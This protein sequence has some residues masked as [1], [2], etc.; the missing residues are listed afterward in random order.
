[1]IAPTETAPKPLPITVP[2]VLVEIPQS[3][4]EAVAALLLDVVD[5]AD[6]TTKTPATA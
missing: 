1:M 4:I 6:T 5:L 2:D 3:A